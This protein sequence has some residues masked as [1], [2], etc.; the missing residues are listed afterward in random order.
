MIEV[1]PVDDRDD[2]RI[3][4]Y[5]D[6]R[7]GRESDVVI[8]EGPTALEQLVG[9][10]YPLRSVLCLAKRL[11]RVRGLLQGGVVYVAP[12]PVLRATVGFDLHRGIVAAAD[13]A[14]EISR[15]SVLATAR[16]IA[17]IE[18]LNDHENLGALF[19]NARGL[20]VDALL[21]DPETAD[22]LYRRAVRVS[23]GHVL[24]A[25]FARIE[26]W[27]AALREVTAA[28]FTVVALTP[29]GEV[30]IDDVDPPDKVAFLLGAEG[31]GL[32]DGALAAADVRARIDMA[33]GVDSLNVATAAAIAFHVV[34]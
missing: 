30:T 25:P 29:R 15:T 22:P 33:N 9:S 13:R 7:D 32:S 28:G 20:G 4:D 19:R 27:P 16:R 6:L 12:E 2:P 8:V 1:V 18:R 14:P 11:D 17:I 31:P 34:R 10:P 23:M 21:L 26:P 3:A 24:R 5:V